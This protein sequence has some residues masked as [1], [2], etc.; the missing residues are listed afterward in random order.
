MSISLSCLLPH[1][2]PFYVTP[3][4]YQ[5]MLT[6]TR[7]RAGNHPSLLGPVLVHQTKTFHAFYYLAS[8]LIRLNPTLNNIKEFGT[9]GECELIKAFQCA[10]P[11]AV[12]LRCTKHLRQNV[13][14]KLRA[15]G[16]PQG[17]WKPFLADIFG[18]HVGTH[19]EQGL[20]DSEN[21]ETF[22]AHLH[23]LQIKW[24]NF[25]RSATPQLEPQFHSWFTSTRVQK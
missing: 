22:H 4:T 23:S 14:D 25:E 17:S 6:V 5:H 1:L 19:L 13:K 21:E 18:A 7:S 12:H 11:N 24:N 8:T 3:L 15:L 20:V 16:L 10:F 2:G 9:D